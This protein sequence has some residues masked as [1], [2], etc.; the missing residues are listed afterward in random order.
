[1]KLNVAELISVVQDGGAET[2]VKDYALTLDK[3]KFDTVIISRR[4]LNN[5]VNVKQLQEREIRIIPIYKSNSFFMKVIQKLND[6]WYVPYKIKK[7]LIREKTDICHMHLNT[8]G[9]IRKISKHIKNVKLFYTCHSDPKKHHISKKSSQKNARYLIKQNGMQMIAL[10]EDM[11]KEINE[12]LEINNT[13]VIRNGIDFIRFKN[14]SESKSQIRASIGIPE[15]A[16]VVG[17][18]GRFVD[19][20]NH[21]FLADVFVELCRRKENAF[22][23]MVGA[24]ELEDQTKDKLDSMNV[25]DKYMILSHRTDIPQLMKAMDVFVFPSK[26]EGLPVTLVEAQVSELRCVISDTINE[27]SVLSENTVA[28]SLNKSFSKW[29]DIILDDSIKGMPCG[30]IEDYD[31]NKE[32][33]RLESLYLG[34]Q[35]D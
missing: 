33:K 9:Y 16:F 2:I 29:C 24:G 1:M 25:K 21:I 18:V 19:V 22:L 26:Y 34:E 15:N 4:I 32:I 11:R 27:E 7:I 3:N 8:L 14:I 20:K 10:H 13:V 5:S 30:N 23:L 31:M 28:V 17:H 6:W 35:I 12:I